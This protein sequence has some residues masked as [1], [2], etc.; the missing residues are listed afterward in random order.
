MPESVRTVEMGPRMVG[1]GRKFDEFE[2]SMN[3]AAGKAAPAAHGIFKD[4][5]LQMT[6][7]D[8][9]KILRGGDTAATSYFK[10]KTSGRLTAAFRPTVEWAMEE[11]GTVKQCKQ[12]TGPVPLGRSKSFD[13]TNHI[14]GKAMDGLFHMLGLEERRIRTGPAARVTPLLQEVFGKR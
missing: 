11:V 13:I 14:V 2:L 3:R 8:A 1:M 12:L 6:F 7:D 4:A 9:R 10:A 5:L